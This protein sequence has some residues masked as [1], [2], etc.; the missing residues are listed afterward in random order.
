M[1]NFIATDLQL[2][3]IFKITQVSFLGH[4]VEAVP[5]AATTLTSD[6]YQ[7]KKNVDHV[8]ADVTGRSTDDRQLRDVIIIIVVVVVVRDVIV[9]VASFAAVAVA[10]A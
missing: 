7:D 6:Q 1:L 10:T 8:E 9:V 4:I 5:F 3:K 2:Y